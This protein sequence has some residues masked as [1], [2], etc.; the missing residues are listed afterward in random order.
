LACI[1]GDTDEDPELGFTGDRED[2]NVG[3]E[4]PELGVLNCFLFFF[5][6]GAFRSDHFDGHFLEV[7]IHRNLQL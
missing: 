4:G 6:Y 3:V 5:K 1:S 7:V 2:F